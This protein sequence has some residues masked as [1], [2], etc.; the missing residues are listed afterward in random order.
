MP[1]K[2]SC[3]SCDR[4]ISAAARYCPKCGTKQPWLEDREVA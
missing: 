2:K 4:R 1:Y 3:E